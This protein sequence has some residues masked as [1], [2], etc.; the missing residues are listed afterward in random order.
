MASDGHGMNTISH[1]EFG[2]VL[3]LHKKA[4]VYADE[5]VCR[6]PFRQVRNWHAHQVSATVG[7]VQPHIIPLGFYPE[8]LL[9]RDQSRAPGYLNRDPRRRVVARQVW[10]IRRA[11]EGTP[12]GSTQTF[13]RHR[14]KQVVARSNFEGTNR[15]LLKGRNENDSRRRGEPA[16]YIAQFDAVERGHPDIKENDVVRTL[17][18][19]TEC[20]A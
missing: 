12:E 4:T 5:P 3:D 2:D 10:L 6:P 19:I 15:V 1:R 7:C 20:V 17:L 11:P 8:Y 16:Q 13:T 14:L 18:K 9:A